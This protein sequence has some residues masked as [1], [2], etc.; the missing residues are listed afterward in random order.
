MLDA[1][2]DTLG[3]ALAHKRPTGSN[4][5]ARLGR[6]VL[7]LAPDWARKSIDKYGNVWVD[8]RR[9]RHDSVA[10]MSHLDTVECDTGPTGAGM[11]SAG[12]IHTGGKCVL[13]ADD[14]AGVALMAGM[15][16]SGHPA[17]YLF[18]QDEESG[19]HGMKYI[20]RSRKLKSRIKGS[21]DVIVSLDRKG[22]K[23]IVGNQ[24]VGDCASREFV[25]SLAAQLGMGHKW[26]HGSYTDG[27]EWIGIVPEI[28]NVSVGYEKAH[29]PNE[30]LDHGYLAALLPALLK[31]DWASL[32]ILGPAV[33]PMD[34]AWFE[35]WDG[36]AHPVPC[37]CCGAPD[38]AE[39]DDR[40]AMC[41]CYS[42][43]GWASN[44]F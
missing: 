24:F 17:L 21:I 8:M 30:T 13:G 11:T 34:Q 2:N 44:V 5:I 10:F 31:V 28:V 22:T 23:D 43:R 38:G 42:C 4:A 19:G 29:G 12:I 32:P 26:A 37:D 33:A 3:L 6:H 39:W 36:P 15:I 41:L 9:G 1:M 7:G 27:C 35:A 25:E 18:T 40:A 16:A 20:L 14:G